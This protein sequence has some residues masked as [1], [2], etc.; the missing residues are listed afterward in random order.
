MEIR[1]SEIRI[2][3]EKRFQRL[4]VSRHPDVLYAAYSLCVAE[5]RKC[6][7]FV[8]L[9]AFKLSSIFPFFLLIFVGLTTRS[10]FCL[11]SSVFDYETTVRW[12]YMDRLGIGPVNACEP[13]FKFNEAL[14]K[15]LK[16]ECAV[17]GQE[18]SEEKF[19]KLG[20]RRKNRFQVERNRS[21]HAHYTSGYPDAPFTRLQRA[22]GHPDDP[23]LKSFLNSFG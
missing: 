19:L 5:I 2:S 20:E 1:M 10:K 9:H 17:T 12:H 16:W 15:T 7:F 11:V 22:P 23:P 3:S 14:S 8:K 6:F 18:K 21:A 13:A 4:H